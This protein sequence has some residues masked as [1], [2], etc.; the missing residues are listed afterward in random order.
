MVRRDRP[1]RFAD[2]DRVLDA[3]RV[4][5]VADAV[6]DV[7]RVLR[8]RVVHR[9]LVVGAAA[10]VIDAEAAADVDV[11]QAGAHLLQL[12]VDV[13]QLGDRVL[14]AADV[15]QLA[16]RMAVH[17]LQ[18]VLHATL[19]EH[20][21]QLED[22][23]DEQPELALLAG[24][25]AP[26]AGAFA[27]ELDAH[28]HA[29]PDA[30]LVRVLE[31]QLQLAEVLDHR[32]D[33]AAELGREDH[34]LDVAVVLEAVADDQ[35]LGFAFGERHHGQQLRLRADLEAE[36][37]IAAI[38]VDFL[39]DQPL[40]VDLDREHRAVAALVFVLGDGRGE[41]VAQARQA[42]AQDVREA[43]DDGRREVARRE[44]GD[45]LVQVDLTAVRPVRPHHGMPRGIDAEVTVAPGVDAVQVEGVLDAPG[46]E[47][48]LACGVFHCVGRSTRGRREAGKKRG[49]R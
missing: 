5:D 3:A 26:A 39:D 9:R 24:R 14:D 21:E 12:R 17:E 40:L 11:L 29:R 13:R 38:A 36:A 47:A 7:A 8:E 10:V 4:A 30:V 27:R 41:G 16:A 35:P 46:A 15:L 20:G 42:V 32:D 48:R 33:R 22:L 25:F 37:E 2:D 19:L 18:A 23:G 28:A 31:D 43:H 34:R 44:P 45:D 6:D 1:P 49:A